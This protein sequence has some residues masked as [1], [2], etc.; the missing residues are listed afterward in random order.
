MLAILQQEKKALQ[1]RYF[2]RSSYHP[3]LTWS[4]H[5]HLHTEYFEPEG[6]VTFSN[7]LQL[8][9]DFELVPIFMSRSMLYNHWKETMGLVNMRLCDYNVFLV[10]LCRLAITLR[11][12]QRLTASDQ[13]CICNSSSLVSY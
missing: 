7:C 5:Q 6:I 12:P 1:V 13:V 9:L 4:I 11:W 10:Y 3:M 8:A 2:N